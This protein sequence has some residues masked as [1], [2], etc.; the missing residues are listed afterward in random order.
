MLKREESH[1]LRGRLKDLATMA[2]KRRHYTT[3]EFLTMAEGSEARVIL[4]ELG[5][6]YRLWGG[7]EEAERCMAI[8]F[9]DRTVEDGI[10]RDV[11][12]SFI[13]VLPKKNPYVRLPNHRDYL[14]ALMNLGLERRVLGDILMD[15]EGCVIICTDPIADF[16]LTHFQRV[17]GCDVTTQKV[18]DIQWAISVRGFKSLRRTVSSPRIDSVVKASTNLSRGDSL[19]L[20]KAGRVFVNGSEVTKASKEIVA[21]DIISVRG[22]G[23]YKVTHI[24]GRTKKDR[25]ILEIDQYT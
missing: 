23:K 4:K 12:I 10:P 6:P 1:L 14:G 7:Y 5:M 2:D 3:T 18:T 21:G 20:I 19:S 9:P 15:D 25:L 16:L 24:G 17:G 11:P 22:H 8:L 13:R